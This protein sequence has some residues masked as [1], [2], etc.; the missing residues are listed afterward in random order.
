MDK[1]ISAVFK[2]ESEGYQA[3]AELKKDPE[4]DAYTVPQAVLIKKENNGIV[5]LDSYDTGLETADDTLLGG[6]IGGVVGILGG[7]IG[8]LLGGSIGILTGSAI[9]AGDSLDNASMIEMVTNMLMDGEVGLIAL[10]QETEA[11]SVRNL[12]SKFDA[13]VIENDAK[14]VAEEIELAVKAQKELEREA[15]A[16]LRE[17]KKEEL[18]KGAEDMRAKLTEGVESL[19]ENFKKQQGRGPVCSDSGKKERT[20]PSKQQPST[21]SS[22]TQSTERGPGLRGSP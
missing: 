4:N 8:M 19:K 10:A 17:S 11:G 6:L 7:P 20:R 18:K 21:T 16:K 13:S 14:E 2:V 5:T 15:R 3:L 12:L 1:I 9:D 22:L